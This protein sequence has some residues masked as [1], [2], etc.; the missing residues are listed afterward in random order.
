MKMMEKSCKLLKT[1]TI[2]KSNI[3]SSRNGIEVSRM[4]GLGFAGGRAFCFL[5]VP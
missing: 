3:E 5:G 2:M 4:K 1:V